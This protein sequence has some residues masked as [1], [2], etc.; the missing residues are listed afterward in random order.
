MTV[1]DISKARYSPSAFI[2][3]P[4]YG[5]KEL[6]GMRKE[7]QEWLDKVGKLIEQEKHS[8][9]NNTTQLTS[10]IEESMSVPGTIIR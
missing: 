3:P 5:L 6:E 8:D 1:L 4:V 2:A 10:Q 7:A 9:N